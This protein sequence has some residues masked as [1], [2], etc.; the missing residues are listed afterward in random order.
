MVA[1]ANYFA[2]VSVGVDESSLKD[3]DKYLKKIEDRFKKGLN[4][5]NGGGAG[6]GIRVN[7]YIDQAKFNKHFGSVIN[8]AI[9]STPI[10][11]KNIG[12]DPTSFKTKVQALLKNTSVRADVTG[13]ITKGSLSQMKAQV[14]A[15]L[16]NISVGVRLGNVRTP[17]TP[18][19]GNSTPGQGGRNGGKGTVPGFWEKMVGRP[20][21]GDLSSPNRRYYDNV[22]GSAFGGIDTIP[23]RAANTALG[24]LGRLGSKSVVGRGLE[25]AGSFLGGA[26]GGA[27]GLVLSG[28]TSIIG[29]S[30]KMAWSTLGTLV[31]AP[32]QM[33]SSAS[34]MVIGAFYK[35]A[36]AALPLVGAFSVVNKNVQEVTAR[37]ISLTSTAKRFGTTSEVEKEWLRNMADTEGVRYSEIVKPYTGFMSGYAPVAGV[38]A[39][40]SMFEAFTQYGRTHGA[41]NQSFGNAY[42]AMQQMASMGTVMSQEFNY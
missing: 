29:S 15:A 40:R 39:S 14:A 10:A 11:I 13:V 22:L 34:N 33:I 6:K 41:T 5:S 2:T 28:V 30:M 23:G 12:I 9:N 1:I 32:F 38:E 31:S 35:L 7:A 19:G 26:R 16:A 4:S 18:G 21:K 24:G 3:V 42:Y 36:L 27:V 37:E 17:K 8:K 20:D 25:A